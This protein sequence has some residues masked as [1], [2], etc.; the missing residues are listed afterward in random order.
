[1]KTTAKNVLINHP[2]FGRLEVSIQ[3]RTGLLMLD[4]VTHLV[5]QYGNGVKFPAVLVGELATA[6]QQKSKEVRELKRKAA[7]QKDVTCTVT[8]ILEAGYMH[9][10]AENAAAKDLSNKL[11]DDIN[12]LIVQ[13][14]SADLSPSAKEAVLE[15][16]KKMP[17]YDKAL[18][19]HRIG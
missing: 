4:R 17:E 11:Y 2:D 3:T 8:H 5:K 18:G 12:R 14:E 9:E 16:E 15:F 6:Y 7:E 1:M 10:K 19:I 13:L